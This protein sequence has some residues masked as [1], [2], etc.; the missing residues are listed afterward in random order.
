[1][2]FHDQ[3][4]LTISLNFYYDFYVVFFLKTKIMILFYE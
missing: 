4:H 1:M 3:F 2:I